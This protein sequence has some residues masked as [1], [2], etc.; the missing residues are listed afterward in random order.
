LSA[1][2][3]TAIANCENGVKKTPALRG[4]PKA[5]FQKTSL[6]VVRNLFVAT[7]QFTLVA[8]TAACEE[9]QEACSNSSG[10]EEPFDSEDHGVG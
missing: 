10:D 4:K 5:P 8:M 2:T 7:C 9:K 1:P 6:R 3:R